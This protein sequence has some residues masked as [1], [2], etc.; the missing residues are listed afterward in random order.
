MITIKYAIDA[1]SV[2]D[3]IRKN[4]LFKTFNISQ[5][6]SILMKTPINPPNTMMSFSLFSFKGWLEVFTVK[7]PFHNG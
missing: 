1:I 6:D 2:K 5:S 3:R 4:K 7:S